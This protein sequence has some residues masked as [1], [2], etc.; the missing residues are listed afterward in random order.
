MLSYTENGR[1]DLAGT[2]NRG[3]T[4]QLLSITFATPYVVHAIPGAARVHE[5]VHTVESQM[6]TRPAAFQG[7]V[8]GGDWFQKGSYPET[9]EDITRRS[10]SLSAL[11]KS[12]LSLTVALHSI[13]TKPLYT[14]YRVLQ[15]ADLFYNLLH[16]LRDLRRKAD[17]S[18]EIFAFD[19][20]H[21]QACLE[22]RYTLVESYTFRI[23]KQ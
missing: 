18:S 20:I 13:H 7:T 1:Y 22:V 6:L 21:D 4:M 8:S 11:E 14:P 16:C 2:M 9:Y 19:S 17:S 12:S 23:S 3:V 5:V 15:Q 10:Q